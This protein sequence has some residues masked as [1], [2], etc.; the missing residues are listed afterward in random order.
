MIRKG[1]FDSRRIYR[2]GEDPAGAVRMPEETGCGLITLIDVI[3]G[4][5]IRAALTS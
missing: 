3:A 1:F 4:R 5:S 2:R